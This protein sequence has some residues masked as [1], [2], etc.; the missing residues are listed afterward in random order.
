MSSSCSA[1]VMVVRVLLFAG[2]DGDWDMVTLLG[3]CG[4]FRRVLLKG[5]NM[6][7]YDQGLSGRKWLMRINTTLTT[8]EIMEGRIDITAEKDVR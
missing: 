1:V 8:T 3:L 7:K 6:Q 4:D 2:R 5:T